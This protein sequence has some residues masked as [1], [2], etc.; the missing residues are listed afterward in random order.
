MENLETIDGILMGMSA[1]PIGMITYTLH[2]YR[3]VLF[4][5]QETQ[6]N[7]NLEYIEENYT[8]RGPHEEYFKD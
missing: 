2:K 3:D 5:K 8:R 4:G 6:I 7:D 1:V